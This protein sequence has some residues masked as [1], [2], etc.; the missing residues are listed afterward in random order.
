ME[1]YILKSA[2]EAPSRH[3]EIDRKKSGSSRALRA[4]SMID[5]FCD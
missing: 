5:N 3:S 4:S 2:Q 1:V